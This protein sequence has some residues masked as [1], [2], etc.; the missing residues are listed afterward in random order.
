[1]ERFN[2]DAICV[3]IARVVFV[4][5]VAIVAALLISECL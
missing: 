3:M 4:I 2:R 5:V 1:M